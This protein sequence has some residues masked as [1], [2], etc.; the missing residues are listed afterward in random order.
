MLSP[1]YSN[2][3]VT[4]QACTVVQN[5][6]N[7]MSLLG[8]YSNV[9]PYF[10]VISALVTDAKVGIKELMFLAKA[11]TVKLLNQNHSDILPPKLHLEL[12]NG[13]CV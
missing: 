5:A 12:P 10:T 11:G 6:V 2:L 13:V 1:N 7:D 4:A 8:Y 3:G 9:S